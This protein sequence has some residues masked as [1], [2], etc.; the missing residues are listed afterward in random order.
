MSRRLPPLNG[1]RAF[2]AAG[3]HLSFSKAAE[4][5]HVTPA[6]VSHQIK[7]LEDHLGV[8]LFRREPRRL[9]LTD[10]AQRALPGIRDAFQRM[11][12]AIEELHADS[13]AH[14]LTV[15]AVPSL[16]AK[17][18]VP[19][20]DRFR[21]AQPDID[22]RL[23][24]TGDV[25]DFQR[26][27]DI[28]MALRYGAGDYKGLEAVELAQGDVV[29]VCSPELLRGE[30]PLRRPED[31][32][33][34][35]LIHTRWSGGE[36]DPDWAEWLRS[37]GID[38]VDHRRGPQFNHTEY[39]L[40]AAIDGQGVALVMEVLIADDVAAGR[41]V[42]PFESPDPDRPRFCYWIVVPPAKMK[43]P[44]VRAFRD[45]LL[46]E[47]ARSREEQGDDAPTPDK[48]RSAK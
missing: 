31:L 28:D 4:E 43:L 22:V 41:L 34:H 40:Q 7:G 8:Q 32:R 2:E 14:V 25:V 48:E 12:E 47:M 38:D 46:D 16:S 35:T 17:W 45:W 3:R 19:R 44:R 36:T 9:L 20:L 33:H 1:L 39:A 24:A 27:S 29:P 15:S 6:A 30:H 13:G 11:G 42:K 18:L 5:L 37:A 21:R 26:D 23:D 10:A